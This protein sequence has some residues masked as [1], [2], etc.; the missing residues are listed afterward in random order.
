MIIKNNNKTELTYKLRFIYL[1]CRRRKLTLVQ[2]NF[3]F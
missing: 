3:L 2:L 1:F